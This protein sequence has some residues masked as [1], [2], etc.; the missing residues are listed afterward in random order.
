MVRVLAQLDVAPANQFAANDNAPI[1]EL[2]V[3]ERRR[4]AA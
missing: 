4:L 3:L 1:G 2:A